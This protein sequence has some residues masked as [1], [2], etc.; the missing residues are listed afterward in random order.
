M[1]LELALSARDLQRIEVKGK[2]V[3]AFDVFRATS[4]IISAFENNCSAVIP[5]ISPEEARQKLKELGGAP[6]KIL[7]AG[8]Q[9]GVKIPGMDLGNSPIE[10]MTA[11]LK[12]KTIV[13]YTSNGTHAIRNAFTADRIFIAALLNAKAVALRLIQEEKDVV[14]GCA[15]RLGEFSLED[16]TAA[17]AVAY[18]IRQ[19]IPEIPA[20]DLVLAA[21][22]CFQN[23][24]NALDIF[25]RNCKHGRYLEKIGFQEDVSFC[26]R[27]NVSL[28]VPEVVGGIIVNRG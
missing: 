20:T 7:I 23:N 1:K 11:D 3:A 5:T 13:M 22:S 18:F 4:T 9:H 21:E 6:E 16:F 14:F 10:Y 12:E 8:E 17:G 25:L 15:G 26:S 19:I 24:K 28:M 2:V 27:L